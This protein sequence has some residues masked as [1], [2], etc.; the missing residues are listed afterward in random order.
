MNR[1][2]YVLNAAHAPQDATLLSL[3]QALVDAVEQNV[4]LDTDP[5]NDPSVLILGAYIA[6]HT[7]ADVNTAGGYHKL[8]SLCEQ[9]LIN[10]AELQ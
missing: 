5:T 1:F 4:A 6:F 10:G 3:A 2:E 7:H 8:L 9:Q